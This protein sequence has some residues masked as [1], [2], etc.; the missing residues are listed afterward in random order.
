MERTRRSVLASVAAGTAAVAGCAAPQNSGQQTGDS[1]YTRVYNEVLP[2]VVV[3]H[4]AENNRKV[5]Q[6]SGFAIDPRTIVTNHHVVDPGSEVNVRLADGQWAEAT[7][8]GSDQHSDLAVLEI[9]SAVTVPKTLSFVDEPA[10]VGEEVVAIGAPFG[11]S[12][13][14]A[15]GII[16]ARGRSVRGLSRFSIPAAIQTDTQVNSGSSGGPLVNLAGDVAGVVF[17]S[18][19]G[20]V[21]FAV[22]AALATRV[23]PELRETGSYDHSYL[24][25]TLLTVEP[26]IADANGLSEPRGVLVVETV[27]RGPSDGILVPSIT[28]SDASGGGTGNGGDA[29]NGS[30]DD[31]EPQIRRRA[32]PTGGDVIVAID[33]T[34]INNT[35]E[36]TRT[37]ALQTRPG[38]TIPIT[39]IRDGEEI[40]VEVTLGELPEE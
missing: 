5:A 8:V 12:E 40:V 28:D 22:S 3:V 16:S 18:Q 15:Q 26:Q 1:P 24:G 11:L 34:P 36:L 35:D 4:V 6:G 38:Q 14:L 37:L 32:I 9:E 29:P 19:G 2:S 13:S 23:I 17:A 31:E 27:D 10:P 7:V 21:A 30:D 20:N 33:G 39:V 25:V